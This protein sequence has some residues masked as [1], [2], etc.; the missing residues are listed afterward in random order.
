MFNVSVV[1]E[2][3]VGVGMGVSM[4]WAASKCKLTTA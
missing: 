3:V 1:A 4:T 2:V